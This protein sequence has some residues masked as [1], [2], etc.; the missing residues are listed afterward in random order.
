MTA[1]VPAAVQLYVSSRLIGQKV[2]VWG[3]GLDLG[4]FTVSPEATI[5][6]PLGAADGYF[7]AAQA[8]GPFLVGYNYVSQG[9]L[10]RDVTPQEA[11]T[12]NGPALGELRRLHEVTF[13]VNNSLGITVGT[14][15]GGTFYPMEFRLATR[16]P[17]SWPQNTLY[18]GIVWSTIQSDYSY[19]EGI[20]FQ[21]TRPYPAQI[22]SIQG[23]IQTDPS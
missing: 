13:L 23:F 2:T 18:S 21:I 20:A 10:L 9:Q 19:N 22:M 3:A 7:T 11:G 8:S 16:N 1:G 12:P 14:N 15:L 6:I 17:G 5:T 4:D